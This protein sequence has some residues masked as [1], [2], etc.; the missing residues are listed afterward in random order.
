VGRMRSR[1]DP[2]ASEPLGT[3]RGTPLGPVESFDGT[4][5]H[6][7][8]VGA[9]PTVVLSHGYSLNLTL[10]HYQIRDLASRYRLV[11]FD[12]RGHGRSQ[13]ARDGDWSIEALAH[14]VRA[15]V[16]ASGDGPVAVVG[17][18]MGGMAAMKFFELFGDDEGRVNGLVLADTT[19]ADV[20][21]GMLPL[22][23]RRLRAAVQGIQ[24]VAMRAVVSVDRP[25]IDRLRRRASDIAWL[26]VRATGFGPNASPSHVA[27]VEK[28][29]SET[30]VDTWF[31]LLPAVTSVDVTPALKRIRV[32]V[33]VIV[34]THDR[35]TPPGA[36]ERIVAGIPGARLGRIA[37][38]GHSPM[39]ECPQTFN[40]RLR[41][42]L[43][44]L[45]FRGGV[46]APRTVE[47]A[48]L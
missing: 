12:Q 19:A 5:L 44:G 48:G 39:L 23:P 38:A 26:V 41:M 29:L 6:V 21:P 7:E 22:L 1:P 40:A 13:P 3:L 18:S 37:G 32:P 16:R 42:F 9:G 10:W 43:D 14:D 11:L 47:S 28:M 35:L 2:E 17:H 45:D 24:S 33:L 8:T 20:T 4:R 34:G 46:E 36:A 15:V 27:F 25:S 31:E 30:S